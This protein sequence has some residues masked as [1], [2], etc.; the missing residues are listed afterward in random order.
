MWAAGRSLLCP[1]SAAGPQRAGP[2][3][4]AGPRGVVGASSL[5]GAPSCA[6]ASFSAAA[7]PCPVPSPSAEVG[8]RLLPLPPPRTLRTRSL[9]QPAR[10]VGTAARRAGASDRGSGEPAQGRRLWSRLPPGSPVPAGHRPKKAPL[11]D[12]RPPVPTPS[13]RALAARHPAAVSGDQWFRPGSSSS[14]KQGR[15]S[16]R[17]A[18][19]RVRTMPGFSIALSCFPFCSLYLAVV[20][21]SIYLCLEVLRCLCVPDANN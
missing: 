6:C 20:L 2:M 4:E 16:D 19:P 14:E 18:T 8:A 12:V 9:K 1:G 17:S 15:V 21:F 10:T 13:V 7:C 3:G 11:T 5:P